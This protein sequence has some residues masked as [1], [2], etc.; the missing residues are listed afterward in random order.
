MKYSQYRSKLKS[1]CARIICTWAYNLILFLKS[2]Q[3]L[4][5][6]IVENH[7]HRQTINQSDQYHDNFQSRVRKKIDEGTRK[8]NKETVNI[9][10][11][12]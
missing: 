1:Y 4:D 7:K 9:A 12:A 10:I 6:P 8:R 5:Y 3:Q 11:I 2:D